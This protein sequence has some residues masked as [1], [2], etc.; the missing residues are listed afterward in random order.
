MQISNEPSHQLGV[1][2]IESLCVNSKEN[3]VYVITNQGQLIGGSLDCKSSQG[4]PFAITLDYVQGL[5]HKNEITGL[6]V[7]IRKQLIVT[8]SRDK[9]VNVWDY[10]T[11]TLEIQTLFP[12][13]CLA[14]AFHPSGLHIIVAMQDKI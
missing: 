10:N 2:Q 7:C 3:F 12:E 11:R 5:F 4:L 14:V 9:T 8:C 13:E 1:N 6:D